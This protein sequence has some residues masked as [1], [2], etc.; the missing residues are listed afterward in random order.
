MC[1]QHQH[2]VT[3][4]S[5]I[6]A[7]N[8]NARDPKGRT[9]LNYAVLLFSP[10]CIKVKRNKVIIMIVVFPSQAILECSPAAVTFRDFK[11]RTALH[12]ACAEGSADCIRALLACKRY[13]IKIAAA[14]IL[15]C[16]CDLHSRDDSGTTPLHW[17]AAANQPGIVQL[18]LRFVAFLSLSLQSNFPL[19]LSFA[20]FV[21]FCEGVEP[22]V[23]KKIIVIILLLIMRIKETIQSA[24][25]S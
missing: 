25:K 17:A 4:L 21:Y 5:S 2:V 16:S 12:Y 15:S 1:E 3:L 24:S 14:Y 10:I 6:P 9:A 19:P 13:F 8:V 23:V 11:G 18:L 20:Y 22:I 7:T